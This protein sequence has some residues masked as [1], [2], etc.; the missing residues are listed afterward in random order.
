MMMMINL[1]EFL[2]KKRKRDE[3]KSFPLYMTRES[4]IC[5]ISRACA[6]NM[7]IIVVVV[8]GI[9]SKI[10][11]TTD[12]SDSTDKCPCVFFSSFVKYHW[13]CNDD[14]EYYIDSYLIVALQFIDMCR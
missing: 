8:E 1:I 13:I 9:V 6:S 14:D 11:K 2:I 12:F 4:N 3:N 10:R 5:Q 7:T